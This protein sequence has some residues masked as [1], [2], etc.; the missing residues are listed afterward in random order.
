MQRDASQ[1]NPQVALPDSSTVHIR[2]QR[3]ARYQRVYDE[4]KR[5]IRGLWVRNGRYYAQLT[6]EDDHTGQKQPPRSFGGS[7]RRKA[8]DM[9]TFGFHRQILA[10]P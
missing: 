7:H 1:S 4:R 5:P 8:A 6:A 9:P 10:Y 3:E 2:R